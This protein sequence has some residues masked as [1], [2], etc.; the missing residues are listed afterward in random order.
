MIR[1]SDDLHCRSEDNFVIGRRRRRRGFVVSG[2]IAK[3]AVG[4]GHHI[5]IAVERR[6]TGRRRL[7]LHV[8]RAAMTPLSERLFATDRNCLA[9]R[10]VVAGISEN[11]PLVVFRSNDGDSGVEFAGGVRERRRVPAT[12]HLVRVMFVTGFVGQRRVTRRKVV[13]F[14]KGFRSDGRGVEDRR[15]K[16]SL[17]AVQV[18]VHRIGE[19]DGVEDFAEVD[20]LLDARA[21]PGAIAD[22]DATVRA[23]V[24][25]VRQRHGFG[26]MY[27]KHSF[28]CYS[29]KVYA[30]TAL[31]SVYV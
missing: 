18:A 19:S 28:D 10:D 21:G 15:T 9:R 26:V 12:R 2:L 1:I 24:P 6:F 16:A 3:N 27:G 4:V 5:V 22:A 23:V 11:L 13:R 14:R 7:Y 31:C 17:R 8:H 30:A 25:D 29:T 20:L